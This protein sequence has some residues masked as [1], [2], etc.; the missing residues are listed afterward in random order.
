[1]SILVTGSTG[2]IGTQVLSFLD[3][4]GFDV[5]ALTRSPGKTQLPGGVTAAQGDLSDIESVRAALAG[6]STLFLLAPNAPDELTKAMLT[7]NAARQAGVTGIVYLS[8]FKGDAYADVPHF[9]SKMTVERMIE[10]YDLPATSLRPAYFIQNALRQRDAL[11]GRGVYGMPVGAKG[12]SVIDIRDITRLR[13]TSW[14]GA[15]MRP[16][17]CLARCS[18]WQDRRR[19]PGKVLPPCGATSSIVRSSMPAMI[20][21]G[22]SS[23]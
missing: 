17:H 13:R 16:I 14:R 22:W 12:I 9:A 11:L 6:V 2:T 19:C 18:S 8:V 1:M 10:A 15:S 4:R 7:L 23:V 21:R 3:G 20:W 5:R